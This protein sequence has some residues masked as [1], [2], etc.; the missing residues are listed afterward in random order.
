MRRSAAPSQ[1]GLQKGS[2][3]KKRKIASSRELSSSNRVPQPANS[4]VRVSRNVGFPNKMLM[5]HR[6][7]ETGSLTST[8]GSL[9]LQN[10]RANGMFDPNQT[11]TGHQPLYFDQMTAIYDHYTVIGSIIRV[12]FVSASTQTLPMIVGIMKNDD[13]TTT[14]TAAGTLCEESGTVSR[15][16]PADDSTVFSLT[17][18]FSAKGTFGGSALSNDNLQGTASADPTEQTIYTL[19]AQTVDGAGTSTCYT[20]T[21]I[22]YIAV[23]EELKDIAT[24]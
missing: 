11:G 15:L 19:F 1:R 12:H 18:K 6:Y 20:W 9:A 7:V 13:T 16:L 8:T 17:Q 22:E 21:E 23:W 2:Y 5:R 4:W 14:P 3:A 24:S 10:F